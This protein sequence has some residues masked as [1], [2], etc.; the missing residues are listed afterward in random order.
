V[1]CCPVH[2]L[3]AWQGTPAAALARFF[4]GQDQLSVTALAAS[5]QSLH[6]SHFLLA[7]PADKEAKLL[8]EL[9]AWGPPDRLPSA[10]DMDSFPYATAC[11]QESLRLYP[12]AA[13]AVRESPAS[14]MQLG[15]LNVPEGTA[16][17]VGGHRGGWGPGGMLAA[18][19]LLLVGGDGGDDVIT[20][21]SP[22]TPR[23]LCPPCSCDVQV[24]IFAMH[25]NPKYWSNPEAYIPER[26]VEGTP[27]AAE[28]WM[29][30]GE[31][32]A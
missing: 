7:P 17:Q 28:V 15:G 16:L 5:A 22:C 13:A 18:A 3:F 9:D 31:G 1:A 14:G 32:P 11:F 10:A 23:L 12:P 25:R 4:V 2:Y 8:A 26:F 29:G 21:R 20:C 24:S 19:A 30:L 27:E 6:H